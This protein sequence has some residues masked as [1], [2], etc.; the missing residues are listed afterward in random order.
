MRQIAPAFSDSMRPGSP[1]GG[2][3]MKKDVFPSTLNTWIGQKLQEGQG[4]RAE[5][6]HYIMRVYADPL[7]VYCLGA[8]AHTLGEPEDLVQGFFADRLGRADY[9]Q[10]WREGGLRLRR[11][12]MN[13]FGFYLKELRRERRKQNKSHSLDEASEPG[14]EEAFKGVESDMDRAFAVAVV[15]Q[16]LQ[17]TRALCEARGQARHWEIFYRHYYE[18][19]SYADFISEFELSAAQAAEMARTAATKF[20]GALRDILA[21]DGAMEREIDAE[22]DSLLAICG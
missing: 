4:G 19:H 16:A 6:N 5:L 2:A 12:L 9:F 18:G 8:S 20:K 15:R 14:D 11:W 22:I 13:G 17:D 1:N 7:R 21:S 10:G 3:R